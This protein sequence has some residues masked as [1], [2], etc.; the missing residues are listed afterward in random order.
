MLLDYDAPTELLLANCV[1]VKDPALSFIALFRMNA[2]ERGDMPLRYKARLPV[3][4][5]PTPGGAQPGARAPPRAPLLAQSLS[6]IAGPMA[7]AMAVGHGAFLGI[8]HIERV[9]MPEGSPFLHT[10]SS[11]GGH[12]TCLAHQAGERRLLTGHSDGM[13]HVWDL[14]K[15]PTAPALSI[16]TGRSAVTTLCCSGPMLCSGSAA[17]TVCA[18]DVRRGAALRATTPRGGAALTRV[19]AS[20][21]RGWLAAA[22]ANGAALAPLLSS[23]GSELGPWAVVSPDPAADVVWN[24]ATG[25]V[26]VP[27]VNGTIKVFRQT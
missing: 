6:P 5:L 12:V 16:S 23:D 1:D 13:V 26:V 7:K 22:T 27:S 11:S 2:S 18:L 9:G 21:C 20:P 24:G 8:A 25:E 3:T 10:W 17:G 19:A 15:Q 14:N 4:R